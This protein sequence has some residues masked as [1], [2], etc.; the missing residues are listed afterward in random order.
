MQFAIDGRWTKLV[1]VDSVRNDGDAIER[2]T[3][4]HDF[5]AQSVADGRNPIGVP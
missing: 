3:T 2:D 4:R 5:V 1:N